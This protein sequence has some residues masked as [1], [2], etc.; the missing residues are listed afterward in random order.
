MSDPTVDF[1]GSGKI[2]RP[3]KGYPDWDIPLNR[4]W[5]VIS[6]SIGALGGTTRVVTGL[7][8][9]LDGLTL[10]TGAGVV[11]FGGA[12]VDIAGVDVIA[13]NNANT[14]VWCTDAGIIDHGTAQPPEGSCLLY[15]IPVED[16]AVVGGISDLRVHRSSG[17]TIA[18][19]TVDIENSVNYAIS[20]HFGFASITRL[21]TAK[22]RLYFSE[23]LPDANYVCSVT[24]WEGVFYIINLIACEADYIEFETFVDDGMGE[25]WPEDTG[26][27]NVVISGE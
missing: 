27:H 6:M 5:D 21:G 11:D 22:Y 12:S 2:S 26:K 16:G 1:L 17:R 10:T 20:N 18:A 8:A 14:C 3:E 19:G 23:T 25:W 15:Y 7:D 24:P 4:N 13:P 9:T